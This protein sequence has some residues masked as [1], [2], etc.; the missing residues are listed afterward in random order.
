MGEG[1][2]GGR[3]A[4]AHGEERK[5]LQKGDFYNYFTAAVDSRYF[6][7]SSTDEQIRS[8]HRVLEISGRIPLIILLVGTMLG[9]M[10]IRDIE[11][12]LY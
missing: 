7:E 12:R 1:G 4:G 2:G 8:G 9:I 10:N 6:L 11:N 3:G 5:I